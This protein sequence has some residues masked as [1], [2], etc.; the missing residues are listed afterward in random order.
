MIIQFILIFIIFRTF[1]KIEYVKFACKLC[2]LW[3]INRFPPRGRKHRAFACAV[4]CP[5]VISASKSCNKT[6]LNVVHSLFAPES[7]KLHSDVFIYLQIS[8]ETCENA[9]QTRTS[10]FLTSSDTCCQRKYFLHHHLNAF[11]DIKYDLI[12]CLSVL[13]R[14]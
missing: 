8:C 12:F 2:N 10:S 4:I 11:R 9:K 1:S 7:A 3:K 14:T 6:C 5:C 13:F